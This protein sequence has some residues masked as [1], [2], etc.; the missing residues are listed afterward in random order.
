M[1]LLRIES[2]ASDRQALDID[3]VPRFFTPLSR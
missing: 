1:E 2:E 3:G